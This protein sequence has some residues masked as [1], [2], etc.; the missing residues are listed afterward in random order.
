MVSSGS[1]RLVLQI[2]SFEDVALLDLVDDVHAFQDLSEH[3]V[4]AVQFRR[5]PS[6]DVELAVG[7]L[8]GAGMAHADGP[9]TVLALLRNLGDPNRLAAPLASPP[10]RPG[11]VTR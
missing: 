9:D 7:V 4:L 8:R 11:H 1:C 3:G 2:R 5:D 10:L 6:R